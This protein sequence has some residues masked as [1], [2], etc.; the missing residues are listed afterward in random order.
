MFSY[1]EL[2]DKKVNPGQTTGGH[3][4]VKRRLFQTHPLFANLNAAHID[5]LV[6]CT[7][8][9]SVPKGS[10]IFVKGSPG[11]SLFAIQ[12]GTVKIISPTAAGHEAM[13][14]LFT[15]GDIFGEI[16]LLDG[17]P[18]SADAF[19][20]T[21]C[22]LLAIE[23]RDFL[24]LLREEPD[25][26]LHMINILCDRLRRTTAQAES[27][28]FLDLPTRLAQALLRLS[29]TQSE[30]N[31]RKIE[32]TQKDL[33]SMIGMSRESTN[34]QLREWED[35]KWV[36]LERNVIVILSTADLEAIAE[37]DEG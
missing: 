29:D 8:A 3:L 1:D 37:G 17:R 5:R 12:K 22:D 21:N 11:A 26:A 6:A 28:M 15:D 13:F 31:F 19:A 18:R 14:S 35:R 33:A 30:A 7:I 10:T 27:L 4:M 36:R 23:R 24:P 20:V 32:I 9:R 16:A 34:K 25:I 2:P